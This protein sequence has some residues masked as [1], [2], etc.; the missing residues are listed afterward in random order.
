VYVQGV[1]EEF[2]VFKTISLF[3]SPFGF[4]I[5]FLHNTGRQPWIGI[6]PVP[7]FFRKHFRNFSQRS[8]FRSICPYPTIF[9]KTS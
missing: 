8:Q 6:D 2:F 5:E 1:L 4:V 9:L 3:D 7:D